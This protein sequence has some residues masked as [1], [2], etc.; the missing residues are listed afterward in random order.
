ML[1]VERLF[2]HDNLLQI[3]SDNPELCSPA[4][5]T[6]HFDIYV[7]CLVNQQSL[8]V[9][10]ADKLY[11]LNQVFKGHQCQSWCWWWSWWW[12]HTHTQLHALIWPGP[13]I[14][15]NIF[16]QRGREEKRQMSLSQM[17]RPFRL[18]SV[19]NS[20][21]AASATKCANYRNAITKGNGSNEKIIKQSYYL[22]RQQWR[23]Q[24]GNCCQYLAIKRAREEGKQM[25]KPET[26][27]RIKKKLCPKKRWCVD[28]K[29]HVQ[30]IRDT[31]PVEKLD[32]NLQCHVC[33]GVCVCGCVCVWGMT[34]ICHAQQQPAAKQ[35][36]NTQLLKSSSSK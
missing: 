28:G 27:R 22:T 13:K 9:S 16:R 26:T 34:A 12:C 35:L 1:Y 24:C 14:A 7:Y 4:I 23:Q 29:K 6:S 21:K 31:T 10:R 18:W 25:E 20:C 2:W 30:Q 11:A 17:G 3:S 5:R 19:H 36:E 33:V 8:S 15:G 32:N